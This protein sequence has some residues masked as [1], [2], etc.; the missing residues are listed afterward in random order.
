VRTFKIERIKSVRILDETYTIPEDFDPR[1]RLADAWGIWYTEAEPVEVVLRFHPRVAHR[2]RETE[3]HASQQLEEQADGGLIWRAEVAE[4]QEMLPWIRGWGADV[5]VLAPEGVREDLTQNVRRMTRLYSVHSS[6]SPSDPDMDRLLRCWGKTGAHIADFHPAFFHM[7][8][9]GH[10]AEALLQPPASPRWRQTLATALGAD[11]EMLGVWLP[12]VVAMHD[13]GKLSAVFQ[14]QRVD[15]YKRLMAEG[16]LFEGWRGDLKIHHSLIGQAALDTLPSL[17]EVPNVLMQAWQDSIGGHHGYFHPR[18]SIRR[19]KNRLGRYEPPLWRELREYAAVA[20]ANH[21]LPL[22]LYSLPAPPELAPATMAL[23]G[24]FILCD[25]IGSDERFFSP[26]PETDLQ[27]YV[28]ES[29]A[30]AH[31]ALEDGGFLQRVSS[32]TATSFALLFPDKQPPRPLQAAV[33]AIPNDVLEGPCLAIIEAPTGEGKTEAALALAHRIARVQ[34]TD[35]L[36]YALPTTATSNQM[37]VRVQAHLRERLNVLTEV[38]LIH[39][40]AFLVEDDLRVDP[41]N[42]N[43]PVD[44]QAMVQWFTSKK[45]AILAPFGV[46]TVDQAELG[47]LNV[48]HVALRLMGLAGKVVIF[49]EVHAYDTYMTTIVER[50]LSWLSTF[51]TSVI[52]LSATLPQTQRTALAGAYGA[53]ETPTTADQ[54]YP[55]LWIFRPGRMPYSAHPTAHQPG[56]TLALRMLYLDEEAAAEKAQWLLEA[57]R[58]GGCACWITN[59]VARA[60]QIFSGLQERAPEDVDLSL[61]HARFPLAE[62]QRREQDLTEKYGPGDESRPSRGIVVGTQVLE[63]SLDLDFDVM[64]SDLAPIDLLLQRAG[65]LQRHERSR[66]DRYADAARL[67]INLPGESD[68]PLDLGVDAKIYDAFIL[69]QTLTIL[70]DKDHLRLPAGYRTLVEAVYGIKEVGSEDRLHEAWLKLQRNR[71]DDQKEAQMR[72]IPQPNAGRAFGRRIAELQFEEDETGAAWIVA[73]T[74]LGRESIN[75]I[76]LERIGEHARLAPD[77]T[78]VNL[79]RPASR[80]MQLHLLRYHLRVSRPEIVR[81]LK[82]GPDLSEVFAD[83]A[84]LK[85]YYPL[86]L[87]EGRAEFEKLNREGE[88]SVKLDPELGLVIEAKEVE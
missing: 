13:I 9:V 31:E 47:A 52:L 80:D 55:G 19:T 74:R 14:S 39:G 63:Q 10:V 49:D 73:Q 36:Y 8:D 51:G 79:D 76:P 15:Q 27:T 20:L 84:R 22:A 57:V 11:P 59:T 81:A 25:W 30:R 72:L 6:E 21:F 50:L 85:G 4:P 66:P 34:G 77:G 53:E 61:L 2:V 41:L 62:R 35:E 42:N 86:W 70:R 40:Q 68:E 7:L 64:V 12:Y 60:Q 46:G 56:R 58:D 69:Q 83:S 88:I 43:N 44:Q 18:Q 38:K 37:F 3:W 71:K 67:W 87:T 17:P 78:E 48:K 65:R 23:T 16:F 1:E 54:D 33:D 28:D 82:S 24:F 29:R 32:E 5:E 75:L 45:R 26:A